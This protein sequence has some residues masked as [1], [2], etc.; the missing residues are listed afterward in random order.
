MRTPHCLVV[1]LVV[2]ACNAT[3]QPVEVKPAKAIAQ[4]AQAPAAAGAIRGQ[5]VERVDAPPYSYLKIATPSGEVWAALLTSFPG[6]RI[7]LNQSAATRIS[8]FREY[9]WIEMEAKPH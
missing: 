9:Q 3:P 7:R 8:S 4:G 6:S 2:A 5:L 1:V